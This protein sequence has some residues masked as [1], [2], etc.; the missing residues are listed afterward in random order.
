MSYRTDPSGKPAKSYGS[1]G[2]FI[3]GLL[4]MMIFYSYVTN[5]QRVNGVW[6]TISS[7]IIPQHIGTSRN[8][9]WESRYKRAGKRDDRG[10]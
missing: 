7:G 9:F 2:P 4:K 8:P 10:F 3:D 6:L 5:Y 1:Y